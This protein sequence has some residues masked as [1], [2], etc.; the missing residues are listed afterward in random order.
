V[1]EVEKETTETLAKAEKGDERSEA[2]K[3]A[4]AMIVQSEVTKAIVPGNDNPTEGP[5]K[6][7]DTSDEQLRAVGLSAMKRLTAI[8][9]DQTE[10]NR[11]RAKEALTEKTLGKQNR[12]RPDEQILRETREGAGSGNPEQGKDHGHDA[13]RDAP[14]IDDDFGLGD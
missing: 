9:A 8:T 5:V 12:D 4:D 14:Q 6:A 7:G 11:E 3:A 10:I 2:E 13:S 1:E